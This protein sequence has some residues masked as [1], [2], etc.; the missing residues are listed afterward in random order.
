MEILADID[1]FPAHDRWTMA[2]EESLLKK[3][4]VY[5]QPVS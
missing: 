3:K 5:P 2:P 1:A 4:H